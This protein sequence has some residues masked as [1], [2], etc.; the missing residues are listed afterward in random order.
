MS[1]HVDGAAVG[2]LPDERHQRARRHLVRAPAGRHLAAQGA[3]EALHGGR[4]RRGGQGA[5]AR[6][7]GPF[8]RIEVLSGGEHGREQVCQ[9]GSSRGRISHGG[10]FR[11][12]GLDTQKD[13]GGALLP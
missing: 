12:F 3:V 8:E 1:V 13:T 4:H 10:S 11:S 7:E 6:G 5:D 9:S 2:D